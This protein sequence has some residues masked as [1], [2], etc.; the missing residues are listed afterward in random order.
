MPASFDI[1][2]TRPLTRLTRSTLFERLRSPT[3][4]SVLEKRRILVSFGVLDTRGV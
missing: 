4:S 2:P 3:V 1:E